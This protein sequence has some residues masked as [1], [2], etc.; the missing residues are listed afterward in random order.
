MQLLATVLRQFN[1]LPKDLNRLS[2][3][4]LDTLSRL[5]GESPNLAELTLEDYD[6]LIFIAGRLIRFSPHTKDYDLGMRLINR[7]AGAPITR[8]RKL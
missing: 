8:T 5:Q 1:A 6:A 7:L 4:Q 2:E 3:D